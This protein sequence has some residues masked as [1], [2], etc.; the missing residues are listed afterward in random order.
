MKLIQIA[1]LLSFLTI[2]LSK[3]I[4]L[5]EQTQQCIRE[6]CPEQ[7]KLCYDDMACQL[8]LNKCRPKVDKPPKQ[9]S[10]SKPFSNV[11]CKTNTYQLL[12]CLKKNDNSYNLIDCAYSNC[13]KSSQSQLYEQLLSN[14]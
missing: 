6:K 9:G 5:N 14:I 11:L 3:R 8:Q 12:A 7:L 1:I 10:K 2:L 4:H 13:E